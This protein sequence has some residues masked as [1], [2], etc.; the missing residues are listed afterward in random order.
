MWRLAIALGALTVPE[1]SLLT[2]N[3]RSF[4]GF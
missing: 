2:A 1:V 4:W 3:Q